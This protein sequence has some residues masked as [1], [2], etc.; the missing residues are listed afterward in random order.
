MIC[1]I[2]CGLPF[3]LQVDYQPRQQASLAAIN[4]AQS[5][6][7]LSG[8]AKFSAGDHL[9]L[10]DSS[11]QNSGIYKIKSARGNTI[12]LE[13]APREDDQRGRIVQV[14][15]IAQRK[16][17]RLTAAA[18]LAPRDQVT[19]VNAN[20]NVSL[21]AK[22]ESTQ[23]NEYSL[24][25]AAPDDAQFIIALN[26]H[27]R[28]SVPVALALV[29]LVS[30]GIGLSHG[31][32]IAKIKLQ[33]FV[34]TLCGLLLYR[35]LTRGFT[36]DQTQGFQ[37]EYPDLRLIATAKFG[38]IDYAMALG[39][40][41]GSLIV[42][43]LGWLWWQRKKN[44]FANDGH[45]PLIP[46][47]LGVSIALCGWYQAKHTP[48]IHS[49]VQQTTAIKVDLPLG[50]RQISL[51]ANDGRGWKQL[52]QQAVP[53][54]NR[55]QQATIP[56][57]TAI[58]AAQTG[59]WNAVRVVVTERELPRIGI[60]A[61]CLILIVVAIAAGIFLNHT[62]YGRYLLALGRNEEAAKYSGINTDRM[63]ILAYVICSLLAGLGGM[64]FVMDVNSAQ[65]V[66]FGNFY[67]LYAIAA[68]VLGGCSLR[69]GEGTIIGVIIGACL[70]RVLKNMIT[71]VDAI[72]THI[73]YAII[74]AVILAGVTADEL[75][76]RYAAKRDAAKQQ[77]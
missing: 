69:G 52:D 59:D 72:P 6:I 46:V 8:P 25:E 57:L 27:P 38:Q 30:L 50:T 77:Q 26:R 2:G 14:F 70:M 41:G 9:R 13:P 60:P 45:W 5:T 3:L 32:L 44:S 15:P 12:T 17:K 63:I 28:T 7:T 68:A 61:P 4:A 71:L 20:G 39:L 36:E 21:T 42:G 64:L 54:H 43:G 65:P 55:A 48:V 66:D 56:S 47:V 11:S 37:A 58:K 19:F 16:A 33:P 76:K 23:G 35:G 34:V 29:L 53:P 18:G 40:L 22:I 10:S 31:F 1:L 24:S 75:I 62:I 49:P 74:G 51:E 67:E 73:E